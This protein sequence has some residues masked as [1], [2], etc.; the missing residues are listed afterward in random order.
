MLDMLGENARA[1]VG[2]VKQL[3]SQ[4][5]TPEQVDMQLMDAARNGLLPISVAFAVQKALQRQNPQPPPPPGTVVGDMMQ[6]LSARQ[7]GVAALPNPVM[8]NAQFAGGGIVAFA[9][10]GDDGLSG[11]DDSDYRNGPRTARTATAG[12]IGS[13]DELKELERKVAS[14]TANAT[15]KTR[16]EKLKDFLKK[17]VSARGILK[18]ATLSP[19]AR[20]AQRLGVAGGA[21]EGLANLNDVDINRLRKYYLD[22]GYSPE[23]FGGFMLKDYAA[24]PEEERPWYAPASDVALRLS[25]AADTALNRGTFGLAGLFGVD[26][27]YSEIAEQ[28]AA[29]AEAAAK[30]QPPAA[31]TVALP[32]LSGFDNPL[33]AELNGIAGLVQGPDMKGY[34]SQMERYLAQ[35]QEGVPT[36]PLKMD[37][38][39]DERRRLNEKYGV[40]KPIEASEKRI[41]ERRAKAEA[42][43]GKSFLTELGL[44]FLTKG[45]MAAGEGKDTMSAMA[46]AI[47]DGAKNYKERKE[48]TDA[49]LDKLDD[50][51]TAVDNQKA[52]IASGEV[53]GAETD[54]RRVEG[55]IRDAKSQALTIRMGMLTTELQMSDAAANRKLQAALQTLT[56][57]ATLQEQ[58]GLV[59][60]QRRLEQLKER[61]TPAQVEAA[62]AELIDY[63]QTTS[64]SYLTEEMKQRYSLMREKIK[65][66][67][68][69]LGGGEEGE[70]NSSG[71]WTNLRTTG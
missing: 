69:D 25:A 31:P 2:K 26:A 36:K 68:P 13:M 43:G 66:E 54:V 50:A 55:Q 4:G 61:G 19:A 48:R 52:A 34:R 20:T 65:K 62:K 12:D 5:A 49:I 38:A 47:D 17:P 59:R 18:A 53:A 41:A 28:D 16:Y 22:K 40:Y 32:S 27:P 37:E 1:A 58:E 9:G 10:G 33:L 45:V 35:S 15:E 14:G 8:D 46:F 63:I 23:D 64:A 6:Q 60:R 42:E 24:M 39:V 7:Q 57:R 11:Y 29:A 56:L 30:Q 67:L 3:Q 71:E 70:A 44:A 21:L 51:Q